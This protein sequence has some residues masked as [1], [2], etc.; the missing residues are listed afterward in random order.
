VIKRRKSPKNQPRN[1]A[2]SS[3]PSQ[4]FGISTDVGLNRND[5]VTPTLAINEQDSGGIPESFRNAR[6]SMH[7]TI[8]NNVTTAR[9]HENGE[10]TTY[11]YAE[12]KYVSSENT[13]LSCRTPYITNPIDADSD[14]KN[15]TDDSMSKIEKGI[16]KIL[17]T[18]SIKGHNI[19]LSTM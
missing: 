17:A 6:D 12:P 15:I 2:D 16:P 18:S 11:S 3:D 5:I 19:L 4:I 1:T 10:D 13:G 7:I 14:S 8:R 9:K